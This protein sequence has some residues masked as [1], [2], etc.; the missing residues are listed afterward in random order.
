MSPQAM[1]WHS[2]FLFPMT[3]IPLLH[4][5]EE[6]RIESLVIGLVWSLM[7]SQLAFKF[8]PGGDWI[9]DVVRRILDP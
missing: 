9:S 1:W 5:E 7:M 6:R 3:L 8:V 2:M 4:V